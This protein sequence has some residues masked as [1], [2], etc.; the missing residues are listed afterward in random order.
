MLPILSPIYGLGLNEKLRTTC[1][2][3]ALG[4]YS[5]IILSVPVFTNGV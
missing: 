2:H 4:V 5:A 3:S 1:S